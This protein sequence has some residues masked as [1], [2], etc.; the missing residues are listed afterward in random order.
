MPATFLDAVDLEAI[1]RR[2]GTPFYLYDAAT[3]R[4]RIADVRAIAPGDGVQARYALKAC[5]LRRV[6]DV[7]READ[8]WIDA[9]SGNEVLRAR[10]AGFPA[11][12]Q[13]PVILL[14]ADVFRDNALAVVLEHGALPNIGS[15]AMI[16]TLRRAGYRGPVG[17]RINPGFGHGHVQATD[18][19]G[20]SSK[21]G[22]WADDLY[23]VRQAAAAAG[24]PV[25]LLHAHVGSGPRIDEFT[26]NMGRLAHFVTE[27]VADFPDLEAV[28]MGGGI[29]HPYRPDA[30]TIDLAPVGRAL[31]EARRAPAPAPGA[32]CASRSS[33][34][35]TSWR[36]AWCWWRASPTSSAPP[37]TTRGRG[38]R[39]S[40]S[41]PASPTWCGRRC[42]ARTTTSPCTA[43]ARTPWSSRSS[44]PACCASRATSSP[45][46]RTSSSTRALPRPRIGD[47]IVLHDTGAYGL[48]MSSHY[49]SLGRAPQVWLEDDRLHLAARRE[50]LA[51]IVR[52]EC[53]EPLD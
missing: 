37:P 12:A 27:L 51:D 22:I 50:A 44:S 41:T 8:V 18:T 36:P 20:P 45:A 49:N 1:A 15:P 11:G 21:H 7:M 30:P 19:G 26:A 17:V 31:R 14:S 9:V 13:P 24:L 53:F 35:A 33:R 10:A 16:D 5:S 32:T 6:L 40:W 38:T 47:L 2:V 48:Q 23:A 46:T 28:N 25:V 34:A 43:P 39:S 29:P 52:A 3:L 4:R 42:T